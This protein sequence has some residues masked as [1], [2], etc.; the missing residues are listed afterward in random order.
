MS[1]EA[2]DGGT[3]TSP[4]G[5]LAPL[6]VEDR[7]RILEAIGEP[8]NEAG[9]AWGEKL[10]RFASLYG[11]NLPG[12]ARRRFGSEA[13]AMLTWIVHC[14]LAAANTGRVRG[15]APGDPAFLS[16]AAYGLDAIPRQAAGYDALEKSLSD[17]LARYGL[18]L[19]SQAPQEA[20]IQPTGPN[21]NYVGGRWKAEAKSCGGITIIAPTMYSL[22]SL[23]VITI[24]LRLGIKIDAVIV[25]KITLSRFKA[26][27]RRDGPIVLNKIWRKLVLRSNESAVKTEFSLKSVADI[28]GVDKNNI[29]NICK[30]NRIPLI[31]VDGFG[32]ASVPAIGEVRH[33]LGIFTG[34]GL[35]SRRFLGAF[36]HGVVNV[37]HG[38]LPAYKGMDVV[39]AP[40][41]EGRYGTVGMTAHLMTPVLDDGPVL[42]RCSIDPAGYQG[43]DAVRNALSALMPILA[44]DAALGY[45][46]GRLPPIEQERTGRQYYFFHRKLV[47]IL[48]DA[49]QAMP[50]REDDSL[51]EIV[52]VFKKE[53][54]TA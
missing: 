17:Q 27:W 24:L 32:D 49:L 19:R 41:L 26:E 23:S 30:E 11:R 38:H 47:A 34:G 10:R 50:E 14:L 51:K 9:A 2:K 33:G 46:S 3:F 12:E 13:D 8:D 16:A 54:G 43:I 22:F 18:W 21:L 28:L 42:E 25:N 39:H 52:S 5:K 35:L 37:H 48:D 31:P 15:L 20:F 53:F 36:S 6:A 40:I 29:K 44:V 4:P 1:G 7:G 45:F